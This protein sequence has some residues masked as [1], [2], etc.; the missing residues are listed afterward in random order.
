MQG[1]DSKMYGFA[2]TGDIEYKLGN[3]LSY[4]LI[5]SVQWC[6]Q[7]IDSSRMSDSEM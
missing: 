1:P 3:K 4:V 7:I 2:G 5:G 6:G